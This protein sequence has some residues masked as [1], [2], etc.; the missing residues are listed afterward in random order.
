M[1]RRLG[2]WGASEESLRVATAKRVVTGHGIDLEHFTDRG[3][4]PERP[5]R[6]LSVGR[7]TPAKDPLTILAALS[8]LV[9]RGLDVHLDLVGAGLAAGDEGYGR[10]VGEQ[11]EL[12][13]LADRVR[14]H[15]SV[16]YPLVP[17]FY[18][19]AS[20]LVNASLTGSVDKVVLEAMAC[21]RPVATCNESFPPILAELGER[22][23]LLT[24]R[25]GEAGELADRLEALLALAPA[26]RERL[27]DDLRAIV[28]RDHDVERLM[29][30]LCGLMAGGEP[31]GR[32]AE[33]G[34]AP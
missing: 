9:S 22:A 23:E 13:G 24:F 2:I 1:R 5:P 6:L 32:R 20:V 27:G 14:L 3:E 25:P 26:E 30:R 12:G 8:I 21:R 31:L 15:G 7:L 29:E 18:R 16:P 11:I 4:A 10:T 19:R 33:G 17:G 34:G 28:A